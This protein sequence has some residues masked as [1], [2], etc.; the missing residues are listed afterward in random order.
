MFS[1][2]CVK[3]TT[4][5]Q[6]E[7]TAITTVTWHMK[8]THEAQ[9]DPQVS[10]E[11]FASSSLTNR[12]G[13][14]PEGQVVGPDPQG[15]WWPPTPNQPTGKEIQERQQQVEGRPVGQPELVRNVDY[16]LVYEQD[17]QIVILPTN[18]SVYQQVVQ[19]YP[20]GIPLKLTLG[21]ARDLVEQ[22]EPLD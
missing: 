16:H 15:L 6:Y 12:N 11:E 3:T 19:A 4:V 13:Q 5:K 8:F 2:S 20:E 10:F 14:Q 1:A 22:A 9:G 7:A 18:S 21:F 17:G